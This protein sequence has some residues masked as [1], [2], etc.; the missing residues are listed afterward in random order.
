[1]TCEQIQTHIVQDESWNLYSKILAED[2]HDYLPAVLYKYRQ[3]FK[4]INF[5]DKKVLEIGSGKGLVAI[6]VAMMGARQ[7]VS[8][9]P[10]LDGSSSKAI[11]IQKNRIKK[12]HLKNITLLTKDFNSW[13]PQGEKYDIVLSMSSINHLYEV[14]FNAKYHEET[15]LFY[16]KIAEKIHSV[17]EP[18]GV[19]V[20]VDACRYGLFFAI[21]NLGIPRPWNLNKKTNVNWRLHQNPAVWKK[22]FSNGRFSKIDTN[23]PVPYRLKNYSKIV[24][25]SIANFFLNASFIMHCHA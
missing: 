21:K 10:E 20:I 14:P 24:N 22:I 4:G 17:L 25:T 7:V 13:D 11:N 9:E 15:N 2:G 19:A 16:T 23:Y 6:Y 1:M 8:M 12:F 5:K 3:R 18:N